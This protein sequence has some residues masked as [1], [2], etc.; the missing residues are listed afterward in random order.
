MT[1]IYRRLPDISG[2]GTSTTADSIGIAAAGVLATALT[3]H[4][5]AKAVQHNRH[6][7]NDEE[8]SE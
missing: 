5:V 4:G 2:F 1:P 8:H 3:V 6:G 7:A